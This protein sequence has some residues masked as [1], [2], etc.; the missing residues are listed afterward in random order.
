MMA[1]AMYRAFAAR[2]ARQ[3]ATA[4]VERALGF[5]IYFV[6]LLGLVLY[7]AY[8][9]PI[10]IDEFLHYALGALPGSREAWGV[11]R[12]TV[13]SFNFNQTGVYM[14]ADFWLLKLFGA[15]AFALRLPS[16]LSAVWLLVSVSK[17]CD[18]RGF[19]CVWKLVAIL[20]I[21]AQA[22][23][24][25]YAAE[26]R[27]YMPLAAAVVGSLS[28][29]LT[30]LDRRTAHIFVAGIVSIE[31]GSLMHPYFPGYWVA[32]IAIGFL[33]AWLERRCKLCLYDVLS[34]CDIRLVVMGMTTYGIVGVLT[35]MRGAPT[36]SFDPFQWIH[37]DVLV[38]TFINNSHLSF[39]F[40]FGI[41]RGHPFF[42]FRLLLLYGM[43]AL[44]LVLPFLP[45]RL[46]I[47]WIALVPPLL[48]ALGSLLISATLSWISY[49]H[50]YW[51]L[52]R[53]WIASVALMPLAFVWYAAELEGL[54]ERL[55]PGAGIS[56]V[57]AC[58]LM[59]CV[60]LAK[61]VPAKL[62]EFRGDARLSVRENLG[63]DAAIPT[64]ND[65]WVALANAN[66]AEGGQVWPIFAKFYGR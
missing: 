8:R 39:I 64:D 20:A 55:H 53:Q 4:E 5:A 57:A 13:L 18:A 27:P 9:H 63:P 3:V 54:V 32:V 45:K 14:M 16:M 40:D 7:S 61:A 25:N 34:F 62:A 10:W 42:G 15:S 52:D 41:G 24:M 60:P 22:P 2:V 23:L 1:F 56:V 21:L 36:L 12:E 19:K 37:R 38:S 44:V 66:L 26:A 6:G 17:L 46:Q 28:F 35:W 51:I 58:L 33:T 43:V 29:Y 48:L 49:E 59:F 47:Q 30:P 65:H 11:I 50:H 31:L